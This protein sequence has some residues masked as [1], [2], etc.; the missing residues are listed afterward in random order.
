MRK[1]GYEIHSGQAVGIGCRDRSR[2]WM[3]VAV[4]AAVAAAQA[5]DTILHVGTT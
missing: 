4:L 3:K 1:D 2:L 5:G